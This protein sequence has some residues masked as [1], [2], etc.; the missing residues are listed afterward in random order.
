M[1]NVAKLAAV[2]NHVLQT[3]EESRVSP[4]PWPH[5]SVANIFPDDFYEEML[6]NLPDVSQME[7]LG[8][9]TPNRFLYWIERKGEHLRVAPFWED[10][11]GELADA[12]WMSLEYKLDVAGAGVVTGSELLHDIPG[13][14]LGPHTDTID[15]LI[16]G[17]VYLPQTNDHAKEGTVLYKCAT[18]DPRGKGH[19][20]TG[21]FTPVK[22]AS[23]VRN[24]AL[25]FVRT[26]VSYHGVRKSP[27]K[28]WLLAFDVFRQ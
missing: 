21:E 12:L 13:Y 25:F 24:N 10:L 9:S 20:L 19:K 8:K 22:T 6:A 18:P 28:R 3:I 14:S 16:T 27:I 1:I 2:R 4:E 5:L 23:Y 17:L 11:H 7:V 15:K 26:D